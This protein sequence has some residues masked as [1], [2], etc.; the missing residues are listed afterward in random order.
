[1][2]HLLLLLFTFQSFFLLAQIDKHIIKLE[3]K[4]A[5]PLLSNCFDKFYI[6]KVVDNRKKKGKI[7]KILKNKGEQKVF[8]YFE[9]NDFENYL[10][11]FFRECSKD[12]V[13]KTA[14]IATINFFSIAE[15]YDAKGKLGQVFL[16]VD[17]HKKDEV[18]NNSPFGHYHGSY[19]EPSGAGNV[20][21][22]FPVLIYRILKEA[23]SEI[24]KNKTFSGIDNF[25]Y[26]DTNYVP[27]K[28]IYL[29]L[30]DYK[31]NLPFETKENYQI[32][33]TDDNEIVFNTKSSHLLKRIFGYSDG[34]NFYI[35]DPTFPAYKI[36]MKKTTTVGR[37]LYVKKADSY[38]V[39]RDRNIIL[40]VS[41]ATGLTG[42]GFILA[43]EDFKKDAVWDT[44]TGE[45]ANINSN[46]FLD[47]I[48]ED[49]NVFNQ[50]YNFPSQENAIIAI[51]SINKRY[52]S[53]SIKI[54]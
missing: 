11:H 36:K 24:G 22:R 10:L 7:G 35:G 13:T 19:A 50:Y 20:S 48:D 34:V 33:Q 25:S 28:G 43:L 2:K 4:Y 46:S 9:Q 41:L 54:K 32:V 26:I 17:F 14:L 21:K 40:G 30:L 38:I 45:I 29:N 39:K 15:D 5:K 53:Q 3:A 1:M 47:F 23:F 31:K 52:H 18:G 6:T 51:K 8:A 27:Q 44:E 37:Y 12:T 42:L 49:D 16:D